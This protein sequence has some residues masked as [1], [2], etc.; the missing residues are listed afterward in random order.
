[1]TLDW[2]DWISWT[3]AAGV[4]AAAAVLLIVAAVGGWMVFPTWP[5]LRPAG[6]SAAGQSVPVKSWFVKLA[7]PNKLVLAHT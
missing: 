4:L 2:T 7:K 3:I 6:T 1:M 5:T